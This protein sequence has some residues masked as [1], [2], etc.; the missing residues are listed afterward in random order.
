MHIYDDISLWGFQCMSSR[1]NTSTKTA[2][3]WSKNTT[4][5]FIFWFS[6]QRGSDLQLCEESGI[7]STTFRARR[8]SIEGKNLN[9]HSHTLAHTLTHTHTHHGVVAL[10]HTHTHANTHSLR[11]THRPN[12]HNSLTNS[13]HG[14]NDVSPEPVYGEAWHSLTW[15]QF[16]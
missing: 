9:T 10:P 3:G 15:L 7:T 11:H 5:Y 13:T 4:I 6:S 1:L 16:H 12:G 14:S 2:L 8:R